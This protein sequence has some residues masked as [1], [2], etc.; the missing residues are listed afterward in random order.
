MNSTVLKEPA[1]LEYGLRAPQMYERTHEVTPRLPLLSQLPVKPGQLVILAIRIVIALLTMAEI[2][3]SE[4]HRHPLRQQQGGHEVA[5]LLPTQG[6]NDRII[7]GAFNATVPA[8]VVIGPI[9]VILAIRFIVFVVI[10]D[11]VVEREAVVAGNKID[12]RI[13]HTPI[14]LIEVAAATQTR[15]K[16]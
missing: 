16:F 15:G 10:T 13:G 12:A 14:A 2:I 3:A 7:S 9:L 6:L 5:H 8:I 4:E 1:P 11:Q